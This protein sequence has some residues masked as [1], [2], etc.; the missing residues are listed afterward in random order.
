[1]SFGKGSFFLVCKTPKA[2]VLSSLTSLVKK[3]LSPTNKTSEKM[4][5][6][7]AAASKRTKKR[8]ATASSDDRPKRA[9]KNPMQAVYDPEDFTMKESE[10][11]RIVKGRGSKLGS[12][13]SV[14]SSV[15]SAKRTGE[16]IAIAHQFLF[17]KK[18]KYNKKEMKA[19]ILDFSGFLKP[20]PAGKKR[21]DKEVEKEEEPIEVS[22]DSMMS[23][24]FVLLVL[25]C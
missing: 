16:E 20:I 17:G 9:R 11:I 14:K 25:D 4:A 18:G 3:A 13:P 2:M 12:F 8:A 6:K 1:M 19:H 15:E 7:K 21:T 22:F 24:S 10:G 5:K 23:P